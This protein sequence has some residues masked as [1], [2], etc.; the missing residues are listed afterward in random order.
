MK[1]FPVKLLR[2]FRGNYR[3]IL[4]GTL[5]EFS[6]ELQSNSRQTFLKKKSLKEEFSEEL[7]RNL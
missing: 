6:M 5:E 3:R 7:R 1:E 4:E 2:N